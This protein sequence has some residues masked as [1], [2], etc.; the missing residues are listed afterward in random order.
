MTA[1]ETLKEKRDE[2][3]LWLEAVIRAATRELD[4]LNHAQDIADGEIQSP[5]NLLQNA[6]EEFREAQD[7][8]EREADERLGVFV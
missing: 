3:K 6:I 2:V 1:T 8:A 7:A 4:Y 5:W